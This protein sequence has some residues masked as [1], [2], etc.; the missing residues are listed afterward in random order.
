MT[1]NQAP[2]QNAEGH[3]C[4]PWCQTDHGEV[5][6]P[7]GTFRF[8][9][10]APADIEV[11]GATGMPDKVIT[12]AFH[13]G[14]PGFEPVV[15]VASIRYGTGDQDPQAWIPPHEAVALA[16]II[17]M[18]DDWDQVPRA[19]CRD[20]PGRR[21]HHGG[22]VMSYPDH[23]H[24]GEYADQRHDHDGDYAE[25]HHRHYDD[26][27]AAR[28]LREDLGH[29]EE[30]IRELENDLRDALER[31]RALEDRLP[32][33]ASTDEAQDDPDEPSNR[34]LEPEPPA[35]TTCRTRR[36]PGE[37]PPARHRG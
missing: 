5:R 10:G 15:S 33:Y 24:R 31:I 18:L 9:G 3:P 22:T 34:E 16:R 1:G 28:G 36:R 6:G 37:D 13:V 17:D 7:A 12:R 4:P 11:R 25:K 23:D 27:S 30:R 29:A 26:E 14:S 32:D 19:D 21:R 8:H 20:P 2:R 35:G